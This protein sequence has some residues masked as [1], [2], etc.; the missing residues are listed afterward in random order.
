MTVCGNTTVS[1]WMC[2]A[3]GL[4]SLLTL[5]T[6]SD[7]IWV[8]GSYLFKVRAAPT[9]LHCVNYML[10]EYLLATYLSTVGK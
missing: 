7:V 4:S 9:L 1:V 6:E 3:S 10:K 5:P 8:L 2:H